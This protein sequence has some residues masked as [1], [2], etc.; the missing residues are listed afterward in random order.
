MTC[1][2]P[3]G[4]PVCPKR[5]TGSF[6]GVTMDFASA[7]TLSIPR[8]FADTMADRGM[9]GMT[10]PVALPCVGVQ[11][12]ATSR[13]VCGDE[14]ATRPRV[15]VVAHPNTLLARV[16]RDDTHDGGPSVR[17]G[18]MAPA[19]IGAAPWRDIGIAMWGAVFPP[20]AG[21]AH[22]PRRR[23]QPSLGAGPLP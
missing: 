20:H 23:G 15:G 3:E 7:I 12:R 21:T 22:R 1:D 2:P 17:R 10:A 14:G 8:P 11:P 5:R 16:V 18:A 4:P 9:G 19:L 13:K 6:T